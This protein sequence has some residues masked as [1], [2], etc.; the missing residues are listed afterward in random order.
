MTE[1]L[2]ND[3]KLGKPFFSSQKITLRNCM[4]VELSY[5]FHI[6]DFSLDFQLWETW[7]PCEVYSEIISMSND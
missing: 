1:K 4:P 7:R 3:I 5:R 6:P 2:V